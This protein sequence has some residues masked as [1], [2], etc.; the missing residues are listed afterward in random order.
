[1]IL[2]GSVEQQKLD[3]ERETE[4][5]YHGPDTLSS[6]AINPNTNSWATYNPESGDV[7][8][9]VADIIRAWPTSQPSTSPTSQPSGRPTSSPTLHPDAPKVLAVHATQTSTS[10]RLN[11]TLDSNTVYSGTLYCAAFLQGTVVSS[12]SQVVTTG[13]SSPY[14]QFATYVSISIPNLVPITTYDV[15][16]YAITQQGYANS[17]TDVLSTKTTAT[18]LCCKTVSFTNTPSSVYS[19]LS[20]YSG[21]ASSTY[22]YTYSLSAAPFRNVTITPVVYT[23]DMEGT[24][25]ASPSAFTFLSSTTSLRGSFILVASSV[26][27][28]GTLRVSLRVSGPSASQYFTPSNITVSLLSTFSPPPAPTLRSSYFSNSGT[29]IFIRFDSNTDLAGKSVSSAF[30]C[31]DLFSFPSASS[32]SCVWSNNTH[33]EATFSRGVSEASLPNVGDTVVVLANRIKALCTSTDPLICGAYVYTP[34]TVNAT[35]SGPT[36]A[37]IPNVVL[38]L[39]AAI[40]GCDNLTVLASLSSGNG[41][42]NW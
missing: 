1:M 28:S 12:T 6:F 22:T 34:S 20:K 13:A 26:T 31:S 35:I 40:G 18:T 37:V 10:I 38:N 15:Y 32:T 25:V 36:S 9:N 19:D 2:G 42:R 27:L 5:V 41:G 30:P 24:V 11:V 8:I 39:P 17:L 4:E 21:S 3:G 23:H 16:C 33:V 14:V 29:S 7:K